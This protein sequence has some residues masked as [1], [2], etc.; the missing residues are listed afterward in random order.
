MPNKWTTGTIFIT[1]LVR[2]GPWLG[3]EP[4]TSRTRSQHS[5]TRL[6]RRRSISLKP[7]STEQWVRVSGLRNQCEPLIG[8]KL[9]SDRNLMITIHLRYPL[10]HATYRISLHM[11][12]LT[13]IQ[14]SPF[15]YFQIYGGKDDVAL[16]NIAVW[17]WLLSIKTM[18]LDIHICVIVSD[19]IVIIPYTN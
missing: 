5:T 16:W 11:Y 18:L 13:H 3:I 9:A 8:L 2:R 4:G 6:P 12:T 1:S 7:T 14:I 17:A 15:L 10:F 19:P